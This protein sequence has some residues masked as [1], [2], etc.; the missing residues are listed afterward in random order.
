M[1]DPARKPDDDFSGW[2]RMTGLG[3]EFIAAVGLLGGI[4][5]YVD[6]HA[7]T[8]PVFILIGGGFG[9]AVGLWII[10]KA[11]MKSFR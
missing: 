5:W 6:K 11:A 4:G 9:F 10:I 8:S 1:T 2:F 3:V 7:G